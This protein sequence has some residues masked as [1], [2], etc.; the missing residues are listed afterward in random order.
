[1]LTRRQNFD[2]NLFEVGKLILKC[3]TTNYTKS[4]LR[5]L[6]DSLDQRKYKEIQHLTLKASLDGWFPLKNE[7]RLQSS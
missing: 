7:H 6:D 2:K 4:Y 3:K 5:E 1:M